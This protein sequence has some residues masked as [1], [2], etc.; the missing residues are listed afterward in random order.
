MGA[1]FFL[2]GCGTGT[3]VQV[4][5]PIPPDANFRTYRHPSGV[6]SLRLPPDWA[7]RDVSHGGVIHVE[8]SAS[9]SAGLPVAV[10][11]V[12]TGTV[13]SAAA[14]LDSM[15][16]FLVLINPK[17]DSYHELSRNAQGDGS[18]RV[19]GVRQTPI[20]ARTLNTF[21]QANGA[22]LAA[23]EADISDL[24]GG[25]MATLRAVINTLRIDP[26]AV[27]TASDLRAVVEGG[28]VDTP[29]VLRFDNLYAWTTPTGEYVING[30]VT[31]TGT[32]PLE[33][34]RI[35]ALLFDASNTVLETA[36][37]VVATE[38]VPAGGTAPFSIR[39]RN[40]RPTQAVRYELQGAGRYAE[41]A[42]SSYLGDDQFIRGNDRA[43]YNANGHLVIVADVVNRTQ[44]AAYF[45]KAIVTVFDDASQVIAADSVFLNKAALLPGEVGR[46]EITFPELGGSA[47]RYTI[48]VEGKSA[49]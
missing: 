49:Q 16:R 18:W 45:V 27:I 41:Y 48:T 37:N 9:G 23:L 29:G 40:G 36:S 2:A 34:I 5:T 35:T 47:L 7:V 19:V 3:A 42:V 22:Y 44:Q 12:N 46:F 31:N 14:L 1:V 17:P 26:S 8:F 15:D 25:A 10:Y 21:F 32:T 13:L 33:A 4:A 11:I 30:V 43:S 39:F 6:F 38:I 24:E 20:G 28:S